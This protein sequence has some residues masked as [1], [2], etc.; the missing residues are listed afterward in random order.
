MLCR[1][2]TKELA[3]VSGALARVSTGMRRAAKVARMEERTPGRRA[4]ARKEAKGKRKVAREKRE[5]V[6]REERRICPPWTKTTVRTPKNS[7][8]G[9]LRVKKICKHGAYWKRAQ[10]SSGNK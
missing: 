8:T 2:F 10:V 7:Q 5:R 9:Q 3:K 1:L 6:G 4:A